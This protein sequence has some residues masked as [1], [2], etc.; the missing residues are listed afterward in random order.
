MKLLSYWQDTA[1]PFAGAAG[2]PVEGRADVAV[3]GGGF[4]GL[5]AALALA[6]RGARVVVLEAGKVAGQASGRNGGHVNNGTAHDIGGL[7]ARLGL[8]AA[9]ALYRAYD[10][11]VDMV[12][13]IVR[14]EQIACDFRRGGKIKLAARPA[15]YDSIARG[16]DLLNRE[17][18]A[19]TALVPRDRIREEVGSDAFFGGLL[20]R[21]SAQMHMGRFG[22]G[23]ADA[24]KR[25]GAVIFEDAPMTALKRL[26]GTAHRI[27]TPRGTLEAAQVLL[28][29]G[30][31]PRMPFFFRRRVIPIG[32]FI[33]ATEPLET[34]Q[35]DSI[36]PT[37]RTA[38]TTRNVGNYFRIS[39][40]NR[41]IWGGRARFALSSPSSDTKSGRVLQAGLHRTFPQLGRPRIDYCWGGVVDLTADRLPRAGE[42]DGL[43]YAMGYSGH[44][45]QMSVH[46]GQQMAR[47]MSGEPQANPLRG[48]DWKP[49]PGHF[50]PP[51]F[52]P[53]VGAYY[54][55]KDAW[56]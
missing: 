7:A 47:V 56:S 35:I 26:N 36:M 4:T 11:A 24:A 20:Y 28:A 5:S 44:G 42:Q 14:E 32:S 54:R 53:L 6:Q 25:H 46:M 22:A 39:P 16:F 10:D 30:Y 15:H 27:A 1:T 41:L 55:L 3:I 43:F 52:M 21:K 19:E 17:V 33:I 31:S 18:D 49:V 12:E 8:E 51:W 13:R 9:R 38:T 29:T 40:D 34:V 45:T 2:G 48:L 50:G 37:R 23:L